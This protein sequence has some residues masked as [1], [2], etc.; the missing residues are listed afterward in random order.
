MEP[1]TNRSLEHVL[2]KGR[3]NISCHFLLVYFLISCPYIMWCSRGKGVKL[4]AIFRRLHDGRA[5]W[6]LV[7]VGCKVARWKFMAAVSGK[8]LSWSFSLFLFCFRI[9]ETTSDQPSNLKKI[10]L[11]LGIK[12]R[13]EGGRR[14]GHGSLRHRS[15]NTIYRSHCTRWKSRTL[16]ITNPR[17]RLRLRIS[18]KEEKKTSEGKIETNS[19]YLHTQQMVEIYISPVSEG[20]KTYKSN[21]VGACAEVRV[22]IRRMR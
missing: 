17:E 5:F 10:S 6:G 7:E 9:D 18:E 8:M 11:R 14:G 2:C 21:T 20:E 13:L 22:W 15:D 16:H 4:F 19:I 3:A 1:P 12:S